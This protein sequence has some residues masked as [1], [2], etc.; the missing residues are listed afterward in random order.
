[1]VFGLFSQIENLSQKV[2]N[3][4]FIYSECHKLGQIQGHSNSLPTT[5]QSNS[6]PAIQGTTP[7]FKHPVQTEWTAAKFGM[8]AW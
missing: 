4:N 8:I 1:M 6:L 3:L 5:L 7:C 2:L